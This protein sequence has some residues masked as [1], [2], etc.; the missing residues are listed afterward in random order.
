LKRTPNFSS[1]NENAMRRC[2][3][4]ITTGR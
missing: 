4:R 3:R 1:E 2:W